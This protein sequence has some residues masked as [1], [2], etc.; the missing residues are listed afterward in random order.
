M[1]ENTTNREGDPEYMF[2]LEN[3]LSPLHPSLFSEDRDPMD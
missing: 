1:G 3:P 2:S